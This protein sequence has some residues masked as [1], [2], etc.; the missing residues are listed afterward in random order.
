MLE[1]IFYEGSRHTE[2][3][4][5]TNRDKCGEG[6]GADRA[7]PVPGRG[8]GGPNLGWFVSQET[9]RIIPEGGVGVGQSLGGPGGAYRQREW[10]LW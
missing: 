1:L 4:V 7:V 9:H 8:S 3:Y 6:R 5:I 10:F 2:G